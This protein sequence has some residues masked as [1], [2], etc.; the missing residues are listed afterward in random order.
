MTLSGRK[1]AKSR[2]VIVKVEWHSGERYL[3][4]GYI[5]TNMARSA[6]NVVAFYNKLGS[7]EQWIKEGK[8]AIKWTLAVTPLFPRQRGSPSASCARL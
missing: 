6:E 5:V 1:L 7:C 2:R 8:G 3:R 4:V